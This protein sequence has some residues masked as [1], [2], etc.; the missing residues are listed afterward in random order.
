MPRKKTKKRK[1][2][3]TRAEQR[4][5]REAAELRRRRKLAV[6]RAARRLAKERAEKKLKKKRSDAAKK[7]WKAHEKKKKQ[8]RERAKKGWRTRWFRQAR[9]EAADGLRGKKR[10]D[11]KVLVAMIDNDDAVWLAFL[12]RAEELGFTS[13]QARDEWFSPAMG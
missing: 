4:K 8:R 9:E 6:E 12:A 2:A 13:S 3:L 11:W 1:K 7:G 10:Q 5:R